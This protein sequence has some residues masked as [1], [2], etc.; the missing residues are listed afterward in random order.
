MR[1]ILLRRA[2]AHATSFRVCVRNSGDLQCS[3]PVQRPLSEEVTI[4]LLLLVPLPTLFPLDADG[5]SSM[6]SSLHCLCGDGGGLNDCLDLCCI[7][8]CVGGGNLCWEAFSWEEKMEKGL[9]WPPFLQ[10]GSEARAGRGSIY[11]SRADE[12][13]ALRDGEEVSDLLKEEEE[14]SFILPACLLLKKWPVPGSHCIEAQRPVLPVDMF[15]SVWERLWTCA[16]RRV[17]RLLFV[18]IAFAYKL[19]YAWPASFSLSTPVSPAAH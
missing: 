4:L 5:D 8:L 2:T 3:V 16:E 14:L 12:V 11:P 17:L 18:L 1:D 9:G 15:C 7:H 6:G 10:R 13:K 19:H